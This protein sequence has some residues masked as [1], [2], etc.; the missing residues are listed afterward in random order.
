MD[1][2]W[3]KM[4]NPEY[5]RLIKDGQF[6]GFKRIVTEYL[7]AG[8]DRWQLDRIEANPDETRKLSKPAIGTESLKREKIIASN[9]SSKDAE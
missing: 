8:H 6:V 7:P 2:D 3:G 9:K 1:E 5:F 4:K